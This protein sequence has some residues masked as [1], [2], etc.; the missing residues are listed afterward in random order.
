MNSDPDLPI[1]SSSLSFKIIE[2]INELEGATLTEIVDDFDRPQSTIH[3]HLTTLTELGYLTQEGRT[4]DVSVRF[5]KFGGRVRVRSKLYRAG[6]NEVVKL[7]EASGEHANLM[8]ESNG[9][10]IFLYKEKGSNSVTLDTYEG[11]EVALHTTAMGK[12][13][14]AELPEA[15]RDR[16]IETH[17][18]DGVTENTI[19]NRK[20]LNTELEEIS[21]RR[22]AV[23][24]EERIDGVRCVAAPITVD[25]GVLGAV[26]VSAPRNRMSGDLFESEIPSMVLDTA[27]VIEVNAQHI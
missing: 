23:D 14:L 1:K 24:D 9:L 3:D 17:G 26:S 8:I 13:I 11:L 27:N 19:T 10:G 22:Y 25:G 7:A 15:A 2:Q 20:R 6:K 5:L 4:F 18:L 12:A 16:I 21:T